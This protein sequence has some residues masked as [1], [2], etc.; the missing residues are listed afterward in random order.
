MYLGTNETLQSYTRNE[1]LSGRNVAVCGSEVFA[2][3][4]ATLVDENVYDLSGL[5]RGL[6]G[7]HDSVDSHATGTN[8]TERFTLLEEATLLFRDVD[9][10]ALDDQTVYVK[11]VPAGVSEPDVTAEDEVWLDSSACTTCVDLC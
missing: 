7:T 6:A 8:A 10:D 4:T 2:F 3:T 9:L 5:L 11:A 1:V